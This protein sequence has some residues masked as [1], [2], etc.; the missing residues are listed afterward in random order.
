MTAGAEPNDEAMRRAKDEADR[1]LRLVETLQ[2]L[3]H[4]EEDA[5]AAMLGLDMRED[6]DDLL[7]RAVNHYRWA[8]EVAEKAKIERR[9]ELDLLNE[10]DK[11]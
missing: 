2:S 1:H 11:S 5:A 9:Q 4:A 3:A 10:L 6:A 7:N 8:A